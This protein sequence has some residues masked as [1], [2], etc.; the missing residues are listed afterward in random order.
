MM[1]LRRSYVSFSSL[2]TDGIMDNP[3]IHHSHFSLFKPI[4]YTQNESLNECWYFFQ[5]DL[6]WNSASPRK[7]SN[8][9]ESPDEDYMK[10]LPSYVNGYKGQDS[11]GKKR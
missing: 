3:G 2:N 7:Y 8:S 9:N 11:Y 4:L 10:D 6:V 5:C 1:I